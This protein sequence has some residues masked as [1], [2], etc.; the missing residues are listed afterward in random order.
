VKLLGHL[1]VRRMIRRCGPQ[2]ELTTKG[3]GL[4]DV[5]ILSRTHGDTELTQQ[6]RC[7]R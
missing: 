6:T 3:Q 7:V 5:A 2:D 1:K 4:C